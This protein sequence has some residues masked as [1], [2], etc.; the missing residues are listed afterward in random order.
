LLLLDPDEV[1]REKAAALLSGED[2]N[3]QA[4]ESAAQAS[5]L[6]SATE[7]DCLVLALSTEH[8]ASEATR[9]LESLNGSA[10]AVP[11]VVLY[12]AVA[13]GNGVG[14]S[15]RSL[16]ESLVVRHAATPGELLDETA[17]F[18]HRPISTLSEDRRQMVFQR[19]Q[20]EPSLQ[21][22]KILII[23]DDIRNIFSLT[24]VLEQHKVDVV[25]AENGKD[26]IRMLESV[27]EIDLALIDI[28]MPDMDGYE[29]MRR[30]RRNRELADLP[31]IAVTAKAMKGD[32]QKCIDAGAS[33]YVAKPVDIELLLSL[34]RVWLGR[35][36]GRRADVQQAML[37]GAAAETH[38][39]V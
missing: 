5:E 7:F 37:S 38:L 35:S 14:G 20:K 30:I 13:D 10:A 16:T 34:L 29:T 25:Y 12:A 15:V 9:F 21:G 1:Q 6:I 31:L 18:L 4:A 33:D 3:I 17:M 23:D 28:M 19:R 2:L 36:G 39:S 27:P 22:R 8:S 32:R 11:P 26:G 24:S